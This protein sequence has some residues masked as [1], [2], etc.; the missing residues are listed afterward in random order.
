M[1]SDFSNCAN[2]QLQ[3][4]I[5]YITNPH[6]Q[7]RS[8]SHKMSQTTDHFQEKS[9][10]FE[11]EFEAFSGFCKKQNLTKSELD[12]VYA[13]IKKELKIQ[14]WIRF[15]KIVAAL[16]CVS[17]TVYYISYV[18]WNISAIGRIALIKMLPIWNWKTHFNDKCL[19]PYLNVGLGSY[20]TDKTIV[21]DYKEDCVVCETIGKTENWRELFLF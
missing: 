4:N 15:L 2:S 6:L 21:E 14:F 19:V 16:T 7:L 17:L 12:L 20:K 10:E 1:Q 3:L 8:V 9:L 5:S 18:N 11:R 13:P